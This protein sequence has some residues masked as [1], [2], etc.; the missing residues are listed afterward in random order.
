MMRTRLCLFLLL[1]GL[2]AQA[3]WNLGIWW[4]VGP[5]RDSALA[6]AF[7]RDLTKQFDAHLRRAG[8]R[9]AVLAR[10]VLVPAGRLPLAGS[11][12]QEHP[13]LRDSLV[14]L[15]WGVPLNKPVPEARFVEETWL[16]AL[17]CPDPSTFA[18]G[19]DL[20]R[21]K[22]KGKAL[23]GTREFPVVKERWARLPTWSLVDTIAVDTFC[24]RLMETDTAKV[25]PRLARQG[26]A[27]ARLLQAAPD[28]VGFQVRDGAGHPV[29]AVLE[30]WRSRPD[31]IRPYAAVLEGAWDSVST[32]V[33]GKAKLG[34]QDWLGGAPVH[35]RKGSNLH[36]LVRARG[37]GRRSPW[38]WVDARDVVL[39]KGHFLISLPA[40][41]S[42]A[43]QQAARSYPEAELLAVESDSTGIWVGLSLPKGGDLVLR[44]L[45]PSGRELFRSSTLE[46][47]PGA[48]EKRLPVILEP[49][50]GYELRM[51]TPT[52]RRLV[53][54]VAGAGVS[55]R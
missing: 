54:F 11:D 45:E 14:D 55:F 15:E 29:P 53:R 33:T 24:L 6:E 3:A 46:L 18:I 12:A 20:F 17:G 9:G 1:C 32:D 25:G 51:D 16:R 23:L 4:E 22:E 49:G 21:V 37:V 8:G 50:S 5:G 19:W 39:A 31:S 34:L 36:A 26:N 7:A 2:P 43:W 42:L 41:S 35:G 27:M 13:D 48:W 52:S 47:K 10:L 44:L 38:A 28:S 40:G 30:I